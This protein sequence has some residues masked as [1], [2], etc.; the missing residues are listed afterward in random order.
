M[1]GTPL[2]IYHLSS[3]PAY[4]A[5]GPSPLMASKYLPDI[6]NSLPPN[7][8]YPTLSSPNPSA[9]AKRAGVPFLPGNLF[10]PQSGT[11]ITGNTDGSDCYCYSDATENDPEGE[12]AFT[13]R[14]LE[15]AYLSGQSE[16]NHLHILASRES[17]LNT[18][19][20]FDIPIPAYASTPIISY[21]DLD[22]PASLDPTFGSYVPS[23]PV[24]LGNKKNGQP[25]LTL[26]S[27]GGAKT[28]YAREHPYEAS[29]GMS[30]ITDLTY[31]T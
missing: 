25:Y 3:Q 29:M 16:L 27:G 24:N 8:A 9:L 7:V 23:V 20:N 15:S 6:P 19:D 21:Y 5:Y 10:C 4:A 1:E 14:H 28:I 26:P 18:C 31:N 12:S 13:K 11:D 22:N 2:N 17:S 30:N